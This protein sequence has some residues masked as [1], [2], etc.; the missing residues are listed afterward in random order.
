MAGARFLAMQKII[1]VRGRS[2]G[3][4]LAF[5][6]CLLACAG[7]VGAQAEFATAP[8]SAKPLVPCQV[9]GDFWINGVP[10]NLTWPA[11]LA[12][13]HRHGQ[14]VLWG[15]WCD[16]EKRQGSLFLGPFKAPE[17]FCIAVAGMPFG[18]GDALA[19]IRVKDNAKRIITRDSPGDAWKQM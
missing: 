4:V 6:C 11:N 9:G 2:I 15:S 13:A 18:K 8:N 10:P 14:L 1:T 19:L 5:L 17:N 16:G 7:K 3:T 12:E